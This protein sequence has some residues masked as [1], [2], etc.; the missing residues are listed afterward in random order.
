ML[1]NKAAA[2]E[3][4]EQ[5]RF[6]ILVVDDDVEL[7][8]NLR[9]ILEE[10]GYFVTVARDGQSAIELCHKKS[11][12][13][14]FVDIK[15]PDVDGVALAEE[16]GRCC[17]YLETILIT[18]YASLDSAM[19][20]V[21]QNK[22]IAYETKPLNL[23]F[24]LPFLRQVYERKRTEDVLRQNEARLRLVLGQ[25]PCIL[26]T[27]DTKLVLTS[28]VGAKLFAGEKLP[29]QFV[30][31]TL[32]EYFGTKDADFVPILAHQRALRGLSSTYEV[33]SGIRTLYCY[34]E[35]LQE[36]EKI[37][38]AIGIALDITER[39]RTEEEH[40]GLSRRLV[41]VQETERR[42]IA[43]ELHDQIGQSLT[44]LKIMLNRLTGAIDREVLSEAQMV[45]DDLMVRVRN[46]SLD[47]RPS[48]L[49][50]L[51]L[52]PTLLWHFE[53]YAA[54]TQ[55]KV[56]FRHSGLDRHFPT[57]ITTAAYRIVQEALT[58]VARHAR[59]KEVKVSAWSDG[60]ALSLNVEDSGVGFDSSAADVALCGGLNGMK[61]RAI[62]LGGQLIISSAPK[63]GTRI[64]A[65]F[66]LPKSS[67]GRK[68]SGYGNKHSAG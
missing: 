11:F 10:E 64:A 53:R 2:K 35:P 37:V 32:E 16:L 21:R 24:L 40:A 62:L 54:S 23:G 39:K 68:E 57:D 14:A 41:E 20:A 22:V 5:A 7:A 29:E 48:M 34:V 61:E 30:G 67:G 6:P 44:A 46:M 25:I 52:L 28:W 58:N 55:I 26:W 12:A 27:T 4:T 63:A 42:T 9:D 8:L 49:D 47:L 66:P 50:D 19:A 13:L 56:N 45:A 59:V 1:E 31:M 43:R 65:E 18:G 33:V 17:Q 38:G 3:P 15:L 60:D 36:Q 51:G